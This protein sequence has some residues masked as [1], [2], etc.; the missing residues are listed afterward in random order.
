MIRERVP[1]VGEEA[2]YV[3]EVPSTLSGLLLCN[4]GSVD[5]VVDTRED[6]AADGPA[7][8]VRVGVGEHVTFPV[9]RDGR[10]PSAQVLW[11]VAVGGRGELD[12]PGSRRP[13]DLLGSGITVNPHD[14]QAMALHRLLAKL[15]DDPDPTDQ[16]AAL[17]RASAAAWEA[18][19]PPGR[20]I[21]NRPF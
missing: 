16:S 1:V 10:Y 20:D 3:C 8:G 13:I 14:M 7:A 17:A 9:E 6:V 12:L 2:T 21:M 19:S 18:S 11:A 15:S 4:T 5:V